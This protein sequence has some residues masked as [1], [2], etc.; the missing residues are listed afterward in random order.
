MQEKISGWVVLSLISAGTTLGV[1]IAGVF[2]ES[3]SFYFSFIP[4]VV[5]VCSTLMYVLETT[6]PEWMR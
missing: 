1:L 4:L 5:F 2:N 3:F 6:G